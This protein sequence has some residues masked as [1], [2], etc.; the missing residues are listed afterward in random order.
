MNRYLRN[1]IYLSTEEQEK[2]YTGIDPDAK[3][4]TRL[5][6]YDLIVLKA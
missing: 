4:E 3:L 6:Y 2:E 5:M 1:R